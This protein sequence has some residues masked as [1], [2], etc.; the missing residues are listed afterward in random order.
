MEILTRAAFE[1]AVAVLVSVGGSTNALIHLLALAR[2]VSVDLTLQDFDHISRRIP[3]LVDCKP[4]GSRWLED[5]HQAGGVPVLLK[6]LESHLNLTTMGV[7]GKTLG[8]QLQDVESPPKW[9]DIIRTLDAPLGPTGSLVILRGSLAPEGAVIKVAAATESLL[10]H[11]GPAV[12][13]DSPDDAAQRID[14]PELRITPEH[15]LVLR[16]AG[17]VGCG[18]PEAGSFPIPRYL[19]Q[20]GVRDMVRISDARMSGTSGGTVVLH[21]SPE[22]ATGGPLALVRDGD[23][24]ELNV[25]EQRLDLLV[26]DSEIERRRS[27][28][29]PPPLPERGW[30][31]LYAERV[32]PAHMGAD[33][34]FLAPKRE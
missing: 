32:L 6:A 25:K 18:M 5:M 7:S 17:P 13:F 15:V 12:V 4:A 33:L 20:D 23:V 8:E 26:D 3:L 27:S 28:F 21:I 31:R 24:I 19:A 16:N 10:V 22:A 11:K 1:N 34:D 9:Q 14:D 30:Q 29:S 2:R